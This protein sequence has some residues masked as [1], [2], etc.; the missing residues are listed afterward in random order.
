MQSYKTALIYLL[1]A[2]FVATTLACD[3]EETSAD[4]QDVEEAVE[5]DSED[6]EETEDDA[7]SEKPEEKEGAGED[8]G[9]DDDS[10]DQDDEDSDDEDEGEES[11]DAEERPPEDFA[12]LAFYATGPIAIVDGEE[13]GAYQFNAVAEEQ[14]SVIPDEAIET[15]GDMVREMLV[16]GMIIAYLI[17]RE[18]EA[19]NIEVSAAE[20]DEGLKAQEQ[21]LLQQFGGDREQM[22]A[23]L[24]AQG[25]TEELLR[26]QVERELAAERLVTDTREISVSEA[27]LQQ[28]YQLHQAQL[29][30]PEQTRARHILLH[31]DEEDSDEEVRQQAEDIA[32]QLEESGDDFA[33]LAEEHSDC[34]T[35]SKGG[36]LGYFTREQ[37]MPEFTEVAFELPPGQI[38]EPVRSNLG[39]HVLRVEERIDEGGASFDDVRDELEMMLQAQ[40]M[41]QAA[42]ELVEELKSAA[43]IEIKSENVATGG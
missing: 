22:T 33:E 29:Q 17:E 12:H 6:A 25:I 19:E 42:A 16:Q 20:V 3:D 28:A 38:S 35:A 14:L 2:L 11:A 34:P 9:A 24:E 40:K 27:E 32:A 8:E 31:V 21:L 37:L 18:I 5:D 39:W 13:L 41:Q 4:S 1:T 36:D 23:M 15:E 26:E 10:E 43:D 30:Q 7:D